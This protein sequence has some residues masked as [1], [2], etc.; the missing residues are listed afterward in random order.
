MAD[1]ADDARLRDVV[2][3]WRYGKEDGVDNADKEPF[4]E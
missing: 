1:R 2:V 4:V 3:G